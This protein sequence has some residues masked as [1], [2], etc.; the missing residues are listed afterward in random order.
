MLRQVK[1]LTKLVYVW[2]IVAF[3]TVLAGAETLVTEAKILEVTERGFILKVGTEPLVVEDSPETRLWKGYVQAK[4]DAFAKDEA[5]GVRV[6]TDTDPPLL[7]EMADASTWN[8]LL[9]IRK[10]P[11]KGTIEKVDA[12]SMLVKFA[13]GRSFEYRHSEK[14]KVNL[15]GKSAALSDLESGKSVYL[16]GR[17][18]PTL[19]TW[20]E[21]VSDS[22]IPVRATASKGKK[23]KPPPPL[24]Q[25]GRIEGKV[26]MHLPQLKLFDVMV[27]VRTLHITYRSDTK[28][29]LN[30][31]P[32]KASALAKLQR[33]VVHYTR[34]KSGRILASKVELFDSADG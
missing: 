14:T 30:G 11:M 31:K 33:A 13:D 24:P 15:A 3:G 29:F 17:L 20:L 4:R 18:L 1:Q 19:D 25:S 22:P 28:F 21:N 27:E 5:V 23:E 9:K 26:M 16:K 12:R 34:D 2:T 32:V 6:K 10:E 7:R 8:W